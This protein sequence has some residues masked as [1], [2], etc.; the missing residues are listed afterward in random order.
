M[1]VQDRVRRFIVDELRWHGKPEEL[2]GDLPL[3]SQGIIDSLG[4]YELVALLEGEYGLTV[5]DGDVLPTNFGSLDA[6][7]AYVAASRTS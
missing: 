1:T 4:I 6:I 7:A 3:I 2:V 5:D